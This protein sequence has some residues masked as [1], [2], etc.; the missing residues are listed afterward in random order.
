M[1]SDCRR[2]LPGTRRKRRNLWWVGRTYGVKTPGRHGKA[3]SLSRS[4]AGLKPKGEF[5][6][7][8]SIPFGLALVVAV[9]LLAAGRPVGAAPP[10]VT[11][12]PAWP[13]ATVADASIFTIGR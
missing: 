10:T 6:M 13:S 12:P 3:L 11:P 8:D 4:Q 5:P 7:R 9:P 2:R 1:G